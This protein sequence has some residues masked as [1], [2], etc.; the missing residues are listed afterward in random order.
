MQRGKQRWGIWSFFVVALFLPVLLRPFLTP[1]P[2]PPPPTPTATSQPAAVGKAIPPTTAVTSPTPLPTET[3]VPTTTPAPTV[4]LATAVATSA[5]PAFTPTVPP[6]TMLTAVAPPAWLVYLNQIRAS[7][8]L[9]PVQESAELSAGAALH[10][11]YMARN[12][13]AIART[14][15]TD[16]PL[17]SETGRTAAWNSN[18]YAT[19]I[20]RS[21]DIWAF[22]FWLSAPFHALPLLDPSLQTVGYGHFRDDLGSVQ[23]SAVLDVHSAPRVAGTAPTPSRGQAVYPLAY[24][25]PGGEI[26][27]LQQSLIEYPEPLSSCPGWHKPVGAPILLQLGSG[28]VIPVVSEAGLSSSHGPLPLCVFDETSYVNSDEF[29]QARGRQILDAQDAVVLIPQQPLAVGETY[30]VRLVVNGETYTWSFTAVSPPPLPEEPIPI[31]LPVPL[32]PINLGSFAWGGQTHDLQNLPLMQ[33][34]GMKW[35]K[36]QLKWRP[37]STPTELV[38]RIW[39]AKAAGFKVLVSVTGDPYPTEIDFAAFVAFMEGVARLPQ[40]PDA[41]EVWNEMNI[42]YE[43]PPG[44]IDPAQYVEQM[45][46]PSYLAIKAA[47]QNISVIS[48]APASTGFD[49]DI[50]AWAVNRY[51]AGMVEA[52][53]ANYLDCVGVHFNESATSPYA[54]SGHPAGSH[55]L[56]YYQPTLQ[57]IYFAFGGARPLCLTELGVLSADGYPALPGRFWWAADTT[58][59]EQALWLAEA[60]TI[61]NHSGYVRLAIIFNVDITHWESDP[62]GGFAI[63]RP[64]GD[65]PFCRL[66]QSGS[67]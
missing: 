23:V 32:Y 29:A 4:F 58:A 57:M 56:W 59:A 36:F 40:P 17:F 11:E 61:A 50:N 38:E 33:A 31:G 45:L 15:K 22:N 49:N 9:P 67:P 34:G 26:W 66:L 5:P 19:N 27:V 24:P 63:L 62:Q 2:P 64:G 6:T 54:D 37:D 13:N 35:L 12:D 48:G 18:I 52:G 7:S 53:A 46:K 1:P 30:S 14:Q 51:V 25:P 60:L 28:S 44:Q 55:Y 41:I 10:S 16:N 20:S 43:W 42:D 47:N 3:A 65:C 8:G 21:N 39:L